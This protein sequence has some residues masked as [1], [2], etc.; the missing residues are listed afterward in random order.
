MAPLSFYE[1]QGFDLKKALFTG[2]KALKE[3]GGARRLIIV[4]L[5]SE[6]RELPGGISVLPWRVFLK[7][8]WKEG[9][10]L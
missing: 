10:L 4:C 6:P 1:T 3:D 5:E 8:L 7:K 9:L 2:L